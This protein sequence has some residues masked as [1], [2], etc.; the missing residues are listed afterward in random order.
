MGLLDISIIRMVSK[1]VLVLLLFNHIVIVNSSHSSQKHYPSCPDEEKSALLQSKD[2]FT[3][4][5]SASRS[6]DAYPKVSSW[7]AASS[8][9]FIFQG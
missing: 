7:K 2:S 3:I 4:D 5:I 6:I 8:A 1:L 9:L